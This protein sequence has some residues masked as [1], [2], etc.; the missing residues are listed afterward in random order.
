[1]KQFVDPKLSPSQVC[2]LLLQR[3]FSYKEYHR[4]K[5]LR[6]DISI[7]G[8]MIDNLEEHYQNLD[9]KS[10]LKRLQQQLQNELR[11]SFL[12]RHQLTKQGE[13]FWQ[14]TTSNMNAARTLSQARILMTHRLTGAVTL[15]THNYSFEESPTKRQVKY[16]NFNS[17]GNINSCSLTPNSSRMDM[18]LNYR[19]IHS[20]KERIAR[21][22]KEEEYK[23]P[24]KIRQESMQ[25]EQIPGSDENS[26]KRSLRVRTKRH[27]DDN[28]TYDDE[29]LMNYWEDVFE[30]MSIQNKRNLSKLKKE[31]WKNS[32]QQPSVLYTSNVKNDD[33][34]NANNSKLNI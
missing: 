26:L 4:I 13:Q 8:S 17:N 25:Q 33:S 1:M 18:D 16:H 20:Y 15:K 11:R 22:K 14:I 34:G 2:F 19:G 3:V 12:Y 27:Y 32:R 10:N 31:E 24:Y 5:T 23:P 21:E 28:F 30:D 6:N 9:R 29:M 7:K